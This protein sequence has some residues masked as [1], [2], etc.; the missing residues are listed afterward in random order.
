[1][2]SGQVGEGTGA[3]QEGVYRQGA[4]EAHGAL[5]QVAG[6]GGR[7]GQALAQP[8][9]GVAKVARHHD[10]LGQGAAGGPAQQ[11]R[12]FFQRPEHRRR[13]HGHGQLDDQGAG[14]VVGVAGEEV[15][16]HGAH[17]GGGAA[18]E[19]AQQPRREEHGAVPQVHVAL[20]GGGDLDDQSHHGTQGGHQGG[21]HQLAKVFHAVYTPRPQSAKRGVE[22]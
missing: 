2:G 14:G 6:D 17:P 11:G 3:G 8:Q 13:R 12:A 18:V 16:Q 5:E 10:P 1:M 22:R 15:G 7:G 20:H 21:Q 9:G 4:G 19:R